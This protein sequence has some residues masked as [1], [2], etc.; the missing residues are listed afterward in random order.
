ML[1]HSRQTRWS[2]AH[3]ALL[4]GLLGSVAAN[5]AWSSLP[6]SG[7]FVEMLRRTIAL[8]TRVDERR[9]SASA[10]AAVIA[11]QYQDEPGCYI[12]FFSSFDYLQQASLALE[13]SYPQL[14]QWQLLPHPLVLPPPP[15]LPAP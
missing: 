12:A 11:R 9:K 14:P 2:S 6:I 1:Q 4:V 3:L 7:L 13:Q 5:T 8:S 10:I 15:K